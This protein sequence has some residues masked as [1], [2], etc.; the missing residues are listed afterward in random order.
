M[1]LDQSVLAGVGNIYA[2]EALFLAKIKSTRRARSLS[3]EE[4][5][6][7]AP[8]LRKVLPRSTTRGGSSIDDYVRPDGSDGGYQTECFV[9][10]RTGEPCRT[11]KAPIQ[12]IVLGQR[13]THFCPEC[14]G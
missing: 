1:L 14:Q 9:Y 12:R 8:A 4:C 11:C 7:H 3:R 5:A 6:R 2:D 10:G 13:S